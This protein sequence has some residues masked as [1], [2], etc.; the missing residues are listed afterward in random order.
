M[1]RSGK[2]NGAHY[3]GGLAIECAL[4]ACIA[5]KT[6][7]HDFPDQKFAASVFSHDL[8]QLLKHAGL[9]LQLDNELRTNRTFAANRGVV[10]SW[11]VDDRYET[12]GLNGREMVAAITSP[13]DGVLQWLKLHW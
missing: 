5:K 4:K 6:K 13:Q 11:R 1:A 9:E 3:L 12:S 10:S 8:R 2:Q 7:R